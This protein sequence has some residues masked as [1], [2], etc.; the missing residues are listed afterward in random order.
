[1]SCRLSQ[2]TIILEEI[3]IYFYV[4]G[5]ST[6]IIYLPCFTGKL[7][8]TNKIALTGAPGSGKSSI[9]KELEYT[10]KERTIAEAAEDIIKY[11]QAKGNPR[12]WELP[13]FQD[14]ILKLQLQRES[15]I[16][17][18][19]ERVFIDRGILD[20]LAYY[21]IQGK[22]PSEEMKKAIEDIKGRYKK[23][24][25]IE[26]GDNCQKTEV[27]R[28]DIEQAKTLQE[29]Q[30]KNYTQAGYKVE[31]IPYLGIEERAKL[32]QLTIKELKGGARENGNQ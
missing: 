11:L 10:W 15:Q 8:M 17:N 16:E 27:R 23:V 18:L 29:L 1:M 24:F 3:H 28:E 20:G 5:L 32:I 31:R 14:R 7:N 26:L 21:Q 13:D 4:V 2:P 9:I 19:E 22:T 12:P 25:L 6:T 30:Y